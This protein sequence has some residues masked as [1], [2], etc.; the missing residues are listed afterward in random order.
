[1]SP[2][3]PADPLSLWHGDG[4][5]LTVAALSAF[6]GGMGVLRD[7]VAL[8]RTDGLPARESAAGWAMVALGLAAIVAANFVLFRARWAW[9][10]LLAIAAL[11]ALFGLLVLAGRQVSSGALVSA[12]GG[13]VALALWRGRRA[14]R[15]RLT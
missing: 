12:A 9:S 1:M 6:A 7:A 3:A 8:L 2:P 13:A 14:L 4:R 15:D 10:M 11:V 5:W